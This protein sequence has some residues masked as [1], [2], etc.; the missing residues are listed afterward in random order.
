MSAREKI[1]EAMKK[2]RSKTYSVFPLRQENIEYLADAIL[3]PRL[4]ERK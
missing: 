1:I 4:G 3:S 2:A